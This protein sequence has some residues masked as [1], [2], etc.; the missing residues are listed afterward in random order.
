MIDFNRKDI[1]PMLIG[2]SSEAFN[3]D[4]YIYELK[5][6]GERCIAYLDP[7]LGTELRNKRNVRMLSKVPELSALHKQVKERCILD[8][9]LMVLKDGK[10]SFYEIQ[11]R[12]IMTNVFKINL[13][14]KQYPASFIPFD[15]LYYKN[16]YISLLPLMERKEYLS[17]AVGEETARMALSKY[18]E[19]Q[20][21]AFYTLAEQQ[22]LEGIVAKRK[23][24]VYIEGKRTKDWIKIKNLKDDDF[25]ICGYIYKENHMISIVLGK[26]DKD[27]LVYKGHVTLGVGGENFRRIKEVPKSD[28]P[29]FPLG[30]YDKTVWIRPQLVCV[31]HFMEY[32]ASGSMRQPVF[33]GLRFDKEPEECQI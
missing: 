32:T 10:P 8:G 17:K 16:N 21:M 28:V 6:D 4:D 12:S 24:S 1:N 2:A 5:W 26:Y 7:K 19:G 31:V 22:E 25:V 13:L 3:S 9:E 18:I 14:S 20:G 33:K 11:K 29:L 23:D 15:I 30:S 27:K